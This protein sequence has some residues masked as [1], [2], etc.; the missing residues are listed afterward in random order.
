M[1]N[2]RTVILIEDAGHYTFCYITAAPC[3]TA[4]VIH[5]DYIAGFQTVLLSVYWVYPERF[6][7]IAVFVADNFASFNFTQP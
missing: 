4:L 1:V 5:G 6:I 2:S 7:L 3:F